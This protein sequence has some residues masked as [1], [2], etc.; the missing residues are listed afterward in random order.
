MSDLSDEHRMLLARMQ[1]NM[2]ISRAK[3]EANPWPLIDRLQN[4]VVGYRVLIAEIERALSPDPVWEFATQN[5]IELL[6]VKGEALIRC[7][8]A[9][10]V[11]RQQK[12]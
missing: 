10:S 4:E 2:A 6:D 7:N 12:R 8:A 11:L 5:N 9:L 1:A 3:I